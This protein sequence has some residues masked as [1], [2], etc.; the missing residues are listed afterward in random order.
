[1][2]S[3]DEPAVSPTANLGVYPWRTISGTAIFVKIAAA[4]IEI[5]V[6]AANT[7][8]AATVATPSPP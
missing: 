7:A 5:P 6:I 8:F 2:P 4:A 3:S 1:M